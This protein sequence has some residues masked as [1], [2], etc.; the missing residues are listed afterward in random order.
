MEATCLALCDIIVDSEIQQRAN[1][2]DPATVNDYAEKYESGV[3]M[4]PVVAFQDSDESIHLADGFHR[5]AAQ[6]LLGHESLDVDLRKGTKRD[7]IFFACAAN[8]SHGLRR[9]NA[10]KRKAIVTLL[11]DAT[12]AKRSDRWIAEKAGVSNN[13]VG[14]VRKQLSSDDSSQSG[15]KQSTLPNIDDTDDE[16]EKTIGKD[17]KSRASKPAPEVKKFPAWKSFEQYMLQLAG[18][19]HGLLDKYES[20][21]A[22]MLESKDWNPACNGM[23]LNYLDECIKG[24]QKLRK[25]FAKHV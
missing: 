2:L 21:V 20:S 24:F 14:D 5:F 11:S 10:D 9:T 7:A 18:I 25:E 22:K 6:Q 19:E 17:G 1:G 3:D 13:F 16:P 4:P 8:G 12:W 15:G 23:A